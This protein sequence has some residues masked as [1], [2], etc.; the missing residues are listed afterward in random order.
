[1]GKKLGNFTYRMWVGL[2]LAS[3]FIFILLIEFSLKGCVTQYGERNGT[4]TKFASQGV[5]FKTWE[6]EMIKGHI[7]NGGF[8]TKPFYFTISN[9]ALVPKVKA[10]FENERQVRLYYHRTMTCSFTSESDCYFLDDI[11]TIK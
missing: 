1:M 9:D 7:N 5:F 6:A 4:I 11:D 8:G 10:A 3:P 2:V